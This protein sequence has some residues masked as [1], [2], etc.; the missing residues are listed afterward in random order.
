MVADLPV[1][2]AVVTPSSNADTNLIQAFA[3]NLGGGQVQIDIGFEGTGSVG[4]YNKYIA[5][6]LVRN[7]GQGTGKYG[8]LTMSSLWIDRLGGQHTGDMSLGATAIA[9][10]CTPPT[11][12]S[13]S[14]TPTCAFGHASQTEGMFAAGFSDAT[15]NLALAWVTASPGGGSCVV[16]DGN[17]PSPQTDHVTNGSG[18]DSLLRFFRKV[19]IRLRCI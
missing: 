8:A 3:I 7:V 2:G 4:N 13:F 5:C 15:S 12:T 17:L 11:I 9:V 18:H 19:A 14:A 6:V 10:D 1:E 16:F